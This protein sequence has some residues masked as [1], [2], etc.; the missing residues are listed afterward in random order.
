MLFLVVCEQFYYLLVSE[1]KVEY[2]FNGIKPFNGING[3]GS[4]D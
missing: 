2:Q 3:A 1:D 4:V